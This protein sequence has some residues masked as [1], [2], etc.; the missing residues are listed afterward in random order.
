MEH[1]LTRIRNLYSALGRGEKKIA[2]WLLKHPRRSDQ[3]IHQRSCHH[4]RL[5]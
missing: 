3:L 4:L 1:T 5:R 2:D